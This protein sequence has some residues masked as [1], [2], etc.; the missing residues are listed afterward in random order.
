MS[1]AQVVEK[2]DAAGIANGR[3]NDIEDVWKHPQLK[4]RGRWR[5]VGSSAGTIQALLPPA[6]L[7][8]VEA[9]MGDI[10][11]LGQHTETLLGELGYAGGDIAALR[12][13]G[14]I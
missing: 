4:A 2:L 8:G 9:S 14:A 11:A 6:N 13:A 10:P 3:M 12:A 1:C 7:A 5:D